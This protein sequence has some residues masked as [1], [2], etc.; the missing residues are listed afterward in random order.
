MSY[1]GESVEPCGAC[2]VCENP[3]K[4]IDATDPAIALFEAIAETGERFGTNHVISVAR[5]ADT[6]KIRQFG[7]DQL[8][9]HGGAERWSGPYL[10]SLVRQAVA[11]DLI[12]VDMQRY[13]RLFLK[14][15]GKAVLSGEQ[16][17]MM[18]EPK[19]KPAKQARRKPAPELLDQADQD[20][21]TKLKHLRREMAQE[22]G[23]PA[24]IIFSD[25]TL[26]DMVQKRPIGR[27][28]MLGVNGVGETK[29]ERFGASF[30]DAING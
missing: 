21:L 2:D 3:P 27:A 5:G 6:E 23:K 26:I 12:G 15:V 4:L 28:Q 25:A 20:L 13:G 14:D 24:Y 8:A 11:A 1:F 22:L 7:H 9:A 29:F 19:A 30:L 18:T 10:K 16:T 17:F